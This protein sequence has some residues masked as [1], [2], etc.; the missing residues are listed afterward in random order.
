LGAKKSIELNVVNYTGIRDHPDFPKLIEGLK[1]AIDPTKLEAHGKRTEF[2][3]FWINVY[4]I[5]AINMIISHPCKEDLF[6]SCGPL[7]SIRQVGEQQP[8]AFAK[9]WGLNAG[10][11][12][13]SDHTL[14][15]IEGMLRSPPTALNATEDS[16]LHSCI[17]CASISCPNLRNEAF[18]PSTLD[19]QMHDQM[20]DF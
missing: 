8:A 16:R 3:A 7:G 12:G 5:F 20:V 19:A 11:V 13:G 14:D 17:V 18:I 1:N 4:N 6:G 9:V 2:Y 15:G 10:N